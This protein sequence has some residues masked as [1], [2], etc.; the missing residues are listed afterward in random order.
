[1]S[2]ELQKVW[3][4][5]LNEVEYAQEDILEIWQVYMIFGMKE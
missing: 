2:Q 3:G 4:F 5:K 1:M